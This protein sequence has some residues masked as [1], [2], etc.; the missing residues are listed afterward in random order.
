MQFAG[1]LR[2]AQKVRRQFSGLATRYQESMVSWPDTFTA[3]VG[4]LIN[5]SCI[6]GFKYNMR[7]VITETLHTPTLRDFAQDLETFVEA[8]PTAN[9]SMMM[10]ETFPS[11]GVERLPD[12]YSAFPHRRN[13]ANMVEFVMTYEQDSAADA[14][15]AFGIKW[16][17][18]FAQPRVSGYDRMYVYQNYANKDEPLKSIYGYDS[19][20]H[21]RLTDLKNKYDPL[22]VFNAYHAIPKTLAGWN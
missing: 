12:N 19:W 22:G 20:R 3:A 7:G 10:I 2:E 18:I 6:K 9:M 17:D 11:R 5:F 14:V 21:R 16:R 13:F 4:G 15:N 1:P 8:N